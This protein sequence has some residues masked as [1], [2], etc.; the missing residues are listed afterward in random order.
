MWI[1]LFMLSIVIVHSTI[2]TKPIDVKVEK[3]IVL[4]VVVVRTTVVVVLYETWDY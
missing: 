2:N 1:I 4:Y 3:N